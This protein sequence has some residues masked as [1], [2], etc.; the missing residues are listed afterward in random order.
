MIAALKSE[1]QKFFSV[2]STYV[3]TLL[4]MGLV[5]FI[6]YKTSND[7]AVSPHPIQAALTIEY[8]AR[9]VM[10]LGGIFAAIIVA[11]SVL[12]E[13]RYNTITYSLTMIRRSKFLAAKLIASVAVVIMLLALLTVAI[14]VGAFTGSLGHT[15][16]L[17]AGVSVM[18]VLWVSA[19]YML[20]FSLLGALIALL[21]RSPVASFAI[22]FVVPSTIEPLLG[23]VLKAKVMYLPFT[24][25]GNVL[26]GPTKNMYDKMSFTS[27]KAAVIFLIYLIVGWIVGWILFLRRDAN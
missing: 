5:W 2:R 26:D 22:I 18:H 24:L 23:L 13:Y 16:H 17:L 12:H 19:F 15:I 27:G 3:I 14:L 8:L 10:P 21:V 4:M 1:F 9:N 6:C 25:L 11:L 7:I 20:G